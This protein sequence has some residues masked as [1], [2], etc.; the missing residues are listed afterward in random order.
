METGLRALVIARQWAERFDAELVVIIVDGEH[1]HSD[2]PGYGDDVEKPCTVWHSAAEPDA[3]VPAVVD[4]VGRD[5][6]SVVCVGTRAQSPFVDVVGTDIAQEL[7]RSV[8]VPVLLVGPHCRT[9]CLDGPVVVA[10]DGLAGGNAVIHTASAWATAV[11]V[12][13]VLLHVH[14]SSVEQLSDVMP[15]LCAARAQLGGAS[16]EMLPSTFPA[17]AIREYAQEVD[18]SLLALSTR[19]STGTLST[20]RP[21]ALR[22]G[23]CARVLVPSW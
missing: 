8:E 11:D 3:L 2:I 21:D 18:A 12:P 7:V 17:G 6:S 19:G 9:E 22:P 4:T 1:D 15:T 14:E 16:L 10:H 13:S 23:S 5:S 20:R